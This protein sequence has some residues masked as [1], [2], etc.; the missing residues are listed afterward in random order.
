M[1]SFKKTERL[2]SKKDIEYL[3]KE[4]KSITVYPLKLAFRKND[5]P[6]TGFPARVLISVPKR[7]FKK[8]VDRNLLKRRIRE[9]YRLVKGN[10]YNSLNESNLKI[11]LHINFIGKNP[12]EFSLI[13]NKLE[14]GLLQLI[15]I[16]KIKS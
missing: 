14:T 3:F 9:S 7:N 2:S 1:F 11:D 6:D 4:N 15:S 5:F 10:L 16:K 13:K 8:A 12:E